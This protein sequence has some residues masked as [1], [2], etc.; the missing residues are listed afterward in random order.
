MP[1][2]VKLEPTPKMTSARRMKWY[3]VP[4]MTPEPLP[5]ASGCSSG[6]PLLPSSVVITGTD[7][8][9]ASSTSSSVASAYITPWPA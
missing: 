6:N 5:R 8:S 3:T 2:L 4:D 7:S 1:C 9:S